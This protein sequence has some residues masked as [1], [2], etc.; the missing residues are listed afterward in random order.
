MSLCCNMKDVILQRETFQNNFIMEKNIASKLSMTL[1]NRYLYIFSLLIFTSSLQAQNSTIKGRIT[2][3]DT[4]EPLIGASVIIVGLSTGVA[5][6]FDGNFVIPNVKSGK[7]ILK[8]SFI[9]Y[10]TDTIRG[11]IV[12]AGKETILDIKLLS[13]DISLKEVEVVARANRES[14][15]ILLL[16]QK[17]A[18]IA[19]Q[20]VGAKEM[21]RKGISDAESAV[22]QVSGVSKQEGVK[23]VFVRGLGDRYNT[24]LLNGFPI[25]SEDPEYKNISLDFFGSDVI[26][27]IG[28]SKVFSS[29]NYGDIGGAVINISRRKYK[30]DW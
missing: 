12:E 18:V 29:N 28:V 15:N 10:R 23:N 16:E 24:T 13:A 1:L 22:A 3:K 26:Q 19:T 7:Y 9:S 17:Q 27:N 6:D 8:T 25:P 30:N 20:A 11:L 4:N 21:S 2:D 5:S 14:E